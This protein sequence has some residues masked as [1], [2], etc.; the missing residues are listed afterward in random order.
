MHTGI[1]LFQPRDGRSEGREF[2]VGM[3]R[4]GWNALVRRTALVVA[5][6]GCSLSS[7]I[8][9]CFTAGVWVELRYS[10]GPTSASD[11]LQPSGESGS[12]A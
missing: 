4:F 2:A 3:S 6:T 11:A 9:S 5:L 10:R 8:D 12:R 7:E 1:D